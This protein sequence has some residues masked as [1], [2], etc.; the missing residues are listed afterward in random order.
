M[1]HLGARLLKPALF[2]ESLIM[3]TTI[4]NRLVAT[5][6]DSHRIKCFDHGYAELLAL[7]LFEDGDLFYMAYRTEVV[8]ARRR[9]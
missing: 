7:E 4:Q 8:D 9:N 2:I 1:T 6:T 3:R 5:H